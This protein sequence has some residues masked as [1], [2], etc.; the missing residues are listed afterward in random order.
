[1]IAKPGEGVCGISVGPG[2]STSGRILSR[3]G[4]CTL[5]GVLVLMGVQGG[6]LTV[7]TDVDGDDEAGVV[8]EKMIGTN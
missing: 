1:M 8:G 6:V 2:N 4:D 3:E 5:D 7:L